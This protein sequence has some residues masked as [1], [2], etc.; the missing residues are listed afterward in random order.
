M[1]YDGWN[2]VPWYEQRGYNVTTMPLAPGKRW[3]INDVTQIDPCWPHSTTHSYVKSLC[4]YL[5]QL[6]T[7]LSCERLNVITCI[8]CSRPI[9][10]TKGEN[11]KQQKQ[12]W[13]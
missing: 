11:E 10:K 8:T 9:H 3:F 6:F 5:P 13:I 4:T 12:T 2:P 7:N 1:R